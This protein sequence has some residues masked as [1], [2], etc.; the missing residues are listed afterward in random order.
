MKVGYS[1]ISTG[2]Q[3]ESLQT[4]ALKSYGCDRLFHDTASGAF[5]DREGLKEAI[6]YCRSGDTLIVWRLDRLGRSLGHLIATVNQLKEKGVGFVSLSES[7]DTITPTG[8][9][10]FHVFGALAEFERS[11]IKA[12]TVA[13]MQSARNRGVKM[14]RPSSLDQEKVK[15]VK[16]LWA[17]G[18]TSTAQL[19]RMFGTSRATVYRAIED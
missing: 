4:E 12:R 9:L 10:V 2:E 3:N 14:G 15:A 19:A 11:L 18:E 13:G 8:K 7:I 16:E 5:D 1:R 6:E 17:K